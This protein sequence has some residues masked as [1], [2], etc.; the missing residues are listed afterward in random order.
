V[1]LGAV[2]ASDRRAVALSPCSAVAGMQGTFP[3]GG[4][5]S[6]PGVA[7][8]AVDADLPPGELVL[9]EL[10]V[11]LDHDPRELL[12]VGLGLPAEDVGSL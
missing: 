11:G 4:E 2:G 9:D 8:S 7:R 10:H 3:D 12:P 6:G 5:S 1:P